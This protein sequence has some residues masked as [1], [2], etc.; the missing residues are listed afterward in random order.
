[1]SVL[2]LSQDP[3][4]EEEHPRID[5]RV[6]YRGAFR[7]ALAISAVIH[8]TAI[9]LYP[10]IL[11]RLPLGV[12]PFGGGAPAFVPQGTELVNLEELPAQEEP[13]A[14]T[15]PEE[16][17]VQEAPVET[18]GGVPG[19]ESPDSI[20]EGIVAPSSAAEL[21]RPE[22]GDLRLW[23]PVDPDLTALTEEQVYRLRLIAEL[24]AM[25][26]SAAAA[27]ERARAAMDWTHTDSEGRK[28]GVSPGKLH[29]G[30]ITVPFPFAFS[31]PPSAG[32]RDRIWEWDD[33]EGGAARGLARQTLKER[34][35][36]IRRRKDA[37]RRADTIRI[38][39]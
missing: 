16:P 4:S 31:A 22:A 9:L 26:D 21:L 25:G 10:R 13:E 39:R 6:R 5:P 7:V 24:E 28:W 35:E 32:A 3:S 8:I 11:Q 1:M 18:P 30:D 23:A 2:P 36:A 27:E 37:E 34:A 20:P 14:A 29:L 15:P 38:R 17:E 12:M 19:V 33:I